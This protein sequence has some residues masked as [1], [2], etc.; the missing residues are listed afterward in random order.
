MNISIWRIHSF[1]GQAQ[2]VLRLSRPGQL[3][4]TSDGD[5][6]DE[7]QVFSLAHEKPT[8]P[9]LAQTGIAKME[10]CDDSWFF[11][12]LRAASGWVRLKHSQKTHTHTHW[13]GYRPRKIPE[14]LV[15]HWVPFAWR[16][17]FHFM[18][19]RK[20]YT[21]WLVGVSEHGVYLQAATWKGNMVIDTKFTILFCDIW[22]MVEK[23]E[24][25]IA[26]SETIGK[27]LP[28][29][30]MFKVLQCFFNSKNRTGLLQPSTRWCPPQW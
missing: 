19:M 5:I 11:M 3:T 25:S 1:L 10:K 30:V 23:T 8:M 6:P 28:N 18:T 26:K 20:T 7:L 24:T 4:K 22:H 16:G 2:R 27:M 13:T 21:H 29:H 9:R 15:S 12:V 14:Q 17:P